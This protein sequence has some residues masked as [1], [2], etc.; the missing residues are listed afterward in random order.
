MISYPIPSTVH[1]E[2]KIIKYF[3]K[4]ILNRHLPIIP[5]PHTLVGLVGLGGVGHQHHRAPTLP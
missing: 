5:A 4:V 3:L 1:T 2:Y